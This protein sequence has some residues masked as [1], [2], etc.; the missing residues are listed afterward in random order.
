MAYCASCG[1]VLADGTTVCPTCPPRPQTAAATAGIQS[2]VAAALT[3]IAGLITGVIFLVLD[4]YKQDRFVRF[5]AFQ[6]IFFNIAWIVL[7][8]VWGIV[9]LVL[10]ALTKGLF[11]VIQLP[12]NLLL[13]LAGLAL[14]IF[15]MFKAYQGIT[16]KL[17][18]IGDLAEKQAGL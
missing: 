10:A 9:G 3:Y 4:P 13:M 12:I 8:I 1:A 11:L 15:L 14:W 18:Y 17:P 2:N 6:S 5:H 7:W 16:W